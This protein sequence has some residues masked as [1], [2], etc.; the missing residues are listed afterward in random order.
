MQRLQAKQAKQFKS[1]MEK[2]KKRSWF[3]GQDTGKDG[4]GVSDVTQFALGT[5]DGALGALPYASEGYWCG[6]NGTQM[7]LYINKTSIL[8]AEKA[9]ADGMKQLYNSIS[10]VDEVVYNCYQA[11]NESLG[12]EDG[13]ELSDIVLNV[14]NNVGYMYTDVA[15]VIT[16]SSQTVANYPYFLAYNVGDFAIRWFWSSDVEAEIP[17]LPKQWYS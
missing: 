11:F 4:V 10:L 14:L 17:G 5:V 13:I 12:L 9:T 7:R 6:K 8:F 15:N 3:L 1:E 16:T 2:P